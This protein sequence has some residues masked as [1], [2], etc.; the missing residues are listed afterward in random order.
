[1][2][3]QNAYGQCLLCQLQRGGKAYAR[4]NYD[5]DT[6]SKHRTASDRLRSLEGGHGVLNELDDMVDLD[7]ESPM[8]HDEQAEHDRIFNSIDKNR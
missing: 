8:R 5:K 4:H 6:C 7:A 2:T 1:M 3:I